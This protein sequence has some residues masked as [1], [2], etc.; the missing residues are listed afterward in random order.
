MFYNVLSIFINENNWKVNL[1][2]RYGFGKGVFL[3]NFFIRMFNVINIGF[4]YIF[5]FGKLFDFGFDVWYNFIICDCKIVEFLLFFKDYI[6]IMKRDYF[7]I[8]CG[9][10]EKF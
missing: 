1:I 8:I 9:L 2:V 10:L 5:D 7:N 6:D 4:L 3:F